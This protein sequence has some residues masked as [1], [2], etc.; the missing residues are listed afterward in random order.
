MK[1]ISRITILLL[2]FYTISLCF[3]FGTKTAFAT[4]TD[5][6]ASC[7]SGTH[8][9]F[10]I[11]LEGVDVYDCIDNPPPS[12]PDPT[13]TPIPPTEAP[14]VCIPDGTNNCPAGPTAPPR[15]SPTSGCN[16][17]LDGSVVCPGGITPAPDTPPSPTP[18]PQCN[19]DL[20]GRLVC[21]GQPTPTAVKSCRE[22]CEELGTT[23]LIN[24]CLQSTCGIRQFCTPGAQDFTCL[25]QCPRPDTGANCPAGE[26]AMQIKTC[27]AE[28]NDRDRSYSCST[29]CSGCPRT[30]EP[31]PLPNT[32]ANCTA[33]NDCDDNKLCT[34]DKCNPTSSGGYCSHD[35]TK[36]EGT[37]CLNNNLVL[38]T[39][40]GLGYC[41][42]PAPTSAPA[43]TPRVP[44][45]RPGTGTG[46]GTTGTTGTT[47]DGGTI[48]TCKSTLTPENSATTLN[49]I[50]SWEMSG[51]SCNTTIVDYTGG[52]E[53]P[54]GGACTGN[55]TIDV[56]HLAGH[57]L[58]F[59]ISS[60]EC[61]QQ[62]AD[63]RQSYIANFG[64][65][66]DDGDDDTTGGTTEGSNACR[67]LKPSQTE[68][69]SPGLPD[70]RYI[71]EAQCSAR[72]CTSKDDCKTQFAGQSVNPNDGYWC[73]GGFGNRSLEAHRCIIL[74]N[75]TGGS[76]P[77]TPPGRP[78]N[79]PA[80]GVPTATPTTPPVVSELR[81]ENLR[82]SC[83]QGRVLALYWAPVTGVSEFRVHVD[84]PT[85]TLT[86][87]EATV[88]DPSFTTSRNITSGT[89]Y[90]WWVKTVKSDGS[91]G[92][93]VN[94][95]PILCEAP[96][97]EPTEAPSGPTATTIPLSEEA[98][99]LDFNRDSCISPADA[100]LEQISIRD[101]GRR[102]GLGEA[103]NARTDPANVN[104]DNEVN[105]E[106]YNYVLNSVRGFTPAMT[107]FLCEGQ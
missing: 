44:T 14:A 77:T 62:P 90:N 15:P 106:D 65:D 74:K 48:A 38:L 53:I 98:A 80:P 86:S 60:S 33:A 50:I 66:G 25:N 29:T 85:A 49:A 99:R 92:P 71:W 79:T 107:R 78:T 8:L 43:S 19:Y 21:S 10:I 67:T 40:D 94:G 55:Q 100:S 68:P 52:G 1:I 93:Q 28:G 51:D 27:N 4:T 12:A 56:T 63:N 57:E 89:T 64:T 22:Q 103:I 7:P 81:A 41:A 70:D 82:G 11:N 31:T 69:V 58:A 47:G 105:V 26:G 73:Y 32:I 88:S 30:A 6:T 101:Y 23:S 95:Q 46:T 59:L 17:Q 61:E 24:E 102:V 36:L 54:V 84:T 104:G 45:P 3:T 2:F 5:P 35:A 87:E 97:A 13:P 96:G 34:L 16:S 39:C 37:A 18:R 91:L 9:E 75:K 72:A 20:S 83:Q 42:G 76:A